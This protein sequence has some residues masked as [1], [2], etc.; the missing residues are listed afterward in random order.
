M[1]DPEMYPGT[2]Y[3]TYTQSFDTTRELLDAVDAASEGL[4]HIVSWFVADPTEV[5]EWGEDDEFGV[6]LFMP[7]KTRTIY[8]NTSNV[9]REAIATWVRESAFPR[10]HRWYGMPAPK[11]TT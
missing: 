7:R 4:N 1:T 2:D 6:L 5:D 11:E 8:F 9:D 10:I 3:P